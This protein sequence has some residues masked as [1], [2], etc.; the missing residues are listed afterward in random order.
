VQFFNIQSPENSIFN[1]TCKINFVFSYYSNKNKNLLMLPGRHINILI[2][3][4]IDKY[5]CNINTEWQFIPQEFILFFNIRLT[6]PHDM[7]ICS[8]KIFSNN[9]KEL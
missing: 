8:N 2:G 6:T 3:L 9:F 5:F 4:F 1:L 7:G